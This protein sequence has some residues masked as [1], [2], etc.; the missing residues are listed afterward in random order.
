MSGGAA[1]AAA[2]GSLKKMFG[3]FSMMVICQETNAAVQH[4]SAVPLVL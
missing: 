2:F 4:A 1:V 3:E